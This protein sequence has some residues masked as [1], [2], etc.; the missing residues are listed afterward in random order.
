M[1]RHL[2]P[3]AG[4]LLLA[5]CLTIGPDYARPELPDPDYADVLQGG[6]PTGPNRGPVTPEALAHWWDRLE[7]PLLTSL[8]EEALEGNRDLR[9]AQ[10]RVRM[11][12]LYV[13]I[14]SAGLYPGVDGAAR[15]RRSRASENMMASGGGNTLQSAA[16]TLATGINVADTLS[17]LATNPASGLK[18]VPGVIASL[19]GS[20]G[21]DLE[22]DFYR[23]GF[24]A[25]WEL[26]I[27]GGTRRG[28][29][30][31]KA[32]LDA[33]Q[34][35]L[36]GV[37]VSLAGSVAE[38]YILLRTF[39]ARLR[40]AETNLEAQEE[41]H[42]L[43]ASLYD[44]GLSDALAVQQARYVVES[45]RASIPALRAGVECTMNTLAVL[46]G[47]LPGVLHER[48]ADATPI[49]ASTLKEVTGIPADALRQR[50]DVRRAERQLAAQTAR[51]GE[52][53]A[54][55][56]PRFALSGSIGLESL[57][58]STLFDGGSDTWSLVP[59]VSWPIFHAGAIRKNV[60]VQTELQEQ[61]LAAYERT[62]LTAVKETRDALTDYARE[63]ERRDSLAA[64]AEAA[65]IALE[66]AQ[67]KYKQGLS[68][69]NNVLDA[70]RSVLT[71]QEQLAI[72]EGS[73][74]ANLVRLYKALGGGW[75]VMQPEVP[76]E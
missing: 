73:I 4:A 19:P 66:V 25:A 30:A 2:L 35:D 37:W 28:I 61:Y 60:Q 44:A 8:V 12:R 40:V 20:G 53:K 75:E 42:E 6:A 33:A 52:A 31:A 54:E 32:D 24:D 51:I 71:F 68:D 14:T 11:A 56:Y 22:S 43:L 21:V 46:T 16:G 26:D 70:Q 76:A 47:V 49:P 18:R 27:F 13:G 1:T 10:S 62:V 50:P 45:T 59:G 41:T 23:A 58:S 15:Y 65:G 48:L 29:E 17:L 39:Q 34:E 9:Q 74:S 7:D 63:Q 72:S 3:I 57:R 64:A 69:F 38:N 36:N 67:D 5:G 55:L